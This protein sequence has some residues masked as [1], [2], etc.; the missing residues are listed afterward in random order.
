LAPHASEPVVTSW[1]LVD[2]GSISSNPHHASQ[3]R[4]SVT[5]R[6]SIRARPADLA[7]GNG[8]IAER[9]DPDELLIAPPGL[10]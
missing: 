5:E 10:I 1:S 8:C 4:R 2:A 9:G 7:D 6:T 3:Q